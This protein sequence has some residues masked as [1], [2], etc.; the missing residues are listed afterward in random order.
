MAIEKYVVDVNTETGQI[1]GT[2]QPYSAVPANVTNVIDNS[3][4]TYMHWGSAVALVLFLA[5]CIKLW[6]FTVK[7]Q[8]VKIIERFGKFKKVVKAGI[9]FKVPF[10]DKIAGE[11]DLRVQQIV[12]KVETKTK[13]NV[14]VT[15]FVAVQYYVVSDQAETAFY[16]LDDYQKQILSY[17]FDNVRSKVPTLE[18]D[19]VFTS[20][21]DIALSVKKELA[22]VMKEFG[23]AISTALVTDIVPDEKV[24]QSMNEINAQSR[25]R[26]AAVEKAEANKILLVKNAE[27]EAES[28]KLQGKGIADQRQ[29]IAEGLE[30][31]TKILTAVGVD[32][33][34][35][36]STLM[37][38][39][40]FDTLKE[41]GDQD[42]V[43]VIFMPSSPAGMTTISEEIRNAVITGNETKTEPIKITPQIGGAAVP[44][45]K[46]I[47]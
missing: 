31:S 25:L 14:F 33:S 3:A 16:K 23:F 5:V 1:T 18:L 27:A 35:V 34:E 6:I 10:I 44:L 9:N 46:V 20:K 2:P 29:A 22:E 45:G 26:L 28:K 24:K 8:N 15:L 32:P 38:T 13:D 4:T 19:A 30:K 11:L 17:V 7:N 39:Q 41:I 37:L 40:Y 47:G 43:K 12:A 36:L 42:N 21:D